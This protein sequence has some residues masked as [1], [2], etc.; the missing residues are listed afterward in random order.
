M[1][2]S[3]IPSFS[4]VVT[5]VGWDQS[6]QAFLIKK[7]VL[8]F[9]KTLHTL[10]F[11][12]SQ[13]GTSWGMNGYAYVSQSSTYGMLVSQ[14]N[15]PFN[16]LCCHCCNPISWT[17]RLMERYGLPLPILKPLPFSVGLTSPIVTVVTC[18]I[19]IFE[20]NLSHQ[21]ER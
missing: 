8:F 6:K 3:L 7:Y 5:V 20:T 17:C 11:N 9:V 2:L 4:L 18:L 16:A 1:Y 10:I 19:H 13:W 21:I 12:V 15:L 14:N